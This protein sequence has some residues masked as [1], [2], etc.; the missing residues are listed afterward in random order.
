MSTNAEA[1]AQT[2]KAAFEASQLIST[3]ERTRALH[4]IRKELDANRDVILKANGEDM[5]VRSLLFYFFPL[6]RVEKSRELN[7][8]G[9]SMQRRRLLRGDSRLRS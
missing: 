3:S 7:G 2:A 4:E 8:A 9:S 5:A 1:I 6:T